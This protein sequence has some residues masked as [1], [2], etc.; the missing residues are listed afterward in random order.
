MLALY[1]A[2]RQ[3]DA[4]AAYREARD[5]LD[6]LGLEPSAELRALEQRILEQDPSLAA[7]ARR[8]KTRVRCACRDDAA[9]RPRLELAAV[10]ALLGRPD[11]RSLTLTGHRRHGKDPARARRG[12]RALARRRLRRPL[13]PL[14]DA[15]LVLPTIARV[16]RLGEASGSASSRRVLR[17]ARDDAPPSSS[18]T[19]SSTC[20]SAFG[21][22]RRRSSRPRRDSRSSRR[23][24]PA[25]RRARARLCGAAA[26][27]AGRPATRPLA[28]RAGRQRCASTPS[29]RGRRSAT[30]SSPTPTRLPSRGSAGRSTAFR[31]RSS[32]RRH[33]CGRSAPRELPKRLGERLSLL[34]RGARDLPGAAAIAPRDARLERTAPRDPA[35]RDVLTGRSASSAGGATR[36]TRSRLV[37]GDGDGRADGAG[38]APR[39]GARDRSSASG[40]PRFGMLETVREYAADLLAASGNE[41]EIRDRQL[42]WLLESS[43]A[44]GSTGYARWTLPGS[45]ASS[46]STTTSARR[47]R[48]P[49]R[50]A[51]RSASFASQRRCGTS[52]GSAGTSRKDDAGSSEASSLRPPSRTSS[53][54]ARWE[55]RG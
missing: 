35:G 36:S 29:A 13:A 19:T 43:K 12:R 51:T 33:G 1:R 27:R 4:L 8:A 24:A 54:H 26:P 9:D 39:R 45:T 38:G 49:R 25:P 14:A 5:A 50:S 20:S 40:R 10:L 42:D 52:G 41:R 46:S 7:P 44:K 16:A 17:R 3:A 15:Q 47:S 23:A 53:G 34:T 21:R 31:S 28:R 30:S 11:T 32:S 6:E 22:R 18:S 2:G 55:R 48:T 37:A